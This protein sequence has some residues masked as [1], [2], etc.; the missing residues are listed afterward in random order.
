MTATDDFLTNNQSHASDFAGAGLAGPP[1]KK[2]AVV[3]CMDARMD[4][5]A[6]L[7][8]EPGD[9]HVMR[10]AGGCVTDD[11]LRSLTISQRKL[12]TEE[13]M[14]IHHTKCGM[15]SFEGEAFASEL[16][17][18]VGTRPPFDIGTFSDAD[19]SVRASLE[20][21]RGCPFLLHR[22]KVRGFVYD[23]DTGALREV[24]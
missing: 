7:G 12:A 16:E 24:A 22:E 11:M 18:E 4:I 17:A 8:L 9:A 19:A 1:R 23:I 13:I 15:A 3:A 20:R 2:I 5:P 14:L 21:V 6:L 10:N